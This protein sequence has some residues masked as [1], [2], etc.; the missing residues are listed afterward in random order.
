MKEKDNKLTYDKIFY[1]KIRNYIE[2][3]FMLYNSECSME[4]CL[5]D[6]EYN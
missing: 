3:L 1:I 2:Y 5:Y 6:Y 4:E